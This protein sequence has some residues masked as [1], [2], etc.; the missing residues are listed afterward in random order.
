MTLE[1]D[2]DNIKFNLDGCSGP[3]SLCILEIYRIRFT[4]LIVASDILI[5][6]I[7]LLSVTF[8]VCY[9][10]CYGPLKGLLLL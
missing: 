2:S 9:D 3:F 6:G 4:L 10:L 1:K 5:E 7:E 8:I